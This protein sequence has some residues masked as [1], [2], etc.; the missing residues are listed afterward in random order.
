MKWFGSMR[1]N[2]EVQDTEKIDHVSELVFKEGNNRSKLIEAL[3]ILDEVI[4]NVPNNYGKRL[5]KQRHFWSKSEYEEYIAKTGE[6][7]EFIMDVYTKVFYYYAVINIEL[8][9]FDEAEKYLLRGLKFVP[10]SPILLNEMGMLYQ[11]KQKISQDN[12]DFDTA[13]KYYMKAVDSDFCP[14]EYLAR[15]FR[16]IGFCLIEL[17]DLDMA[18]DIFNKSIEIYDTETARR[19]LN[20]INDLR[21]GE[22][23]QQGISNV[24][25]AAQITTFAYLHE[26]FDKMPK[27]WNEIAANNSYAYIFSKAAKV[28]SEG[29][30]KYREED[31]FHYPLKTW[32]EEKILSGCRQIV[33]E[34]KGLT[35]E[36]CFKNLTEEEFK[37][38]L[39]LFHF[40]T[41]SIEK[42]NEEI[43][44]GSFV[45]KMH[46][47]TDAI[48][49]C[50]MYCNVSK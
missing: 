46:K 2:Q 20:Y 10:D 15:A 25:G 45:H 38:L 4:K 39:Q 34:C 22:R 33:Y 19:E 24:I 8:C 44:K 23:I 14:S 27:K 35:A 17:G 37:N 30:N 18:E 29:T 36:T 9:N 16:G 50:T 47:D 12:K 32:N 1:D 3:S 21:K 43:I 48:Y 40:N 41:V 42:I 5:T 6:S 31:Y 11:S 49:K 13:I 7:V 28:V 26:K